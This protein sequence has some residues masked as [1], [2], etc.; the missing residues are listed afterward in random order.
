MEWTKNEVAQKI[1][2]KLHPKQLRP[3]RKNQ[4]LQALS[5]EIFCYPPY[6]PDIVLFYHLFRSLSNFIAG[7]TFSNGNDLKRY[8]NLYVQQ[9]SNTMVTKTFYRDKK[10]L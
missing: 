4:K 2:H 1:P 6:A 9:S 8:L 3:F 7:V 10:R 5:W